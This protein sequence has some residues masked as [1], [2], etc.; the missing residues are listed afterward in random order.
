VNASAFFIP[1]PEIHGQRISLCKPISAIQ[2]VTN[3][4]GRAKLGLLSQLGPGTTVE[5]CGDGFNERTA[6][7][8]VNGQCYFVFLQ[9]LES[10]IPLGMN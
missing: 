7:V 5:R 9:D 1:S 8:R 2:L 6:K 3:E 4:S 10:Q